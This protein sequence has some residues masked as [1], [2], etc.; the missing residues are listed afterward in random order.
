MAIPITI[1]RLGWNM[2]EGVFVAWLKADGAVVR[3]G[4]SVFSL[5]SEKA[6]E[7]IEC[8]DSGIL[9]IPPDGP[10]E[11]DKVAVGTII[12]FLVQA[13]ETAPF[14]QK[15]EDV[16]SLPPSEQVASPSVRR[17]ARERGIDLQTVTASGDGGRITAEDLMGL[18][19]TSSLKLP[20]AK[21]NL[22]RPSN[23]AISPRARRV[24]TELH[25]DWKDLQGSGRT[26]RIRECD[27]RAAASKV[28][29]PAK[30][31]SAS[32]GTPLA[33]SSIR[34]TIAERMLT[35]HHSTA[36]VTLTTTADATN[37]VNLRNQ[38]KAALQTGGDL[39][40]TY[41]VLLVKL[42]ASAL[43]KHPL[44]NACWG[45]DQIHVSPDIH[46]GVAVDTAAGLMVPVLTDV[47]SLSLKQLAAR[48]R[49]LSERARQRT[50]H[51]DELRGGTFTVTNLGAFGIDGFTPIINYPQCAILGIGRIE[52]RPAV[53]GDLMVAQEQITLSLTFDH[54]IVD[55]AP[56]A[57][58]LQ[59]LSGF[60][61][62]PGPWLMP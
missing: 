47:A 24:A 7:D 21:T 37:L 11:G 2:E 51:A 45:E 50:L 34:R 42:T 40:P 19:P 9:R 1:P 33:V 27:V 10:R 44:L 59:M 31:D 28:Q 22:P 25:I 61:E 43:Q 12:G 41:T 38:F 46:I 8:L 26:G 29:A 3:A 30:P 23:P 49:D 4:E 35:S 58:F 13:G 36:P 55:G 14:L 5:E 57:R 60:I 32:R 52:R 48:S 17:L 53:L 6:T 18:E 15:R 20:G 56:A 16:S 62:N 39:V 54:R